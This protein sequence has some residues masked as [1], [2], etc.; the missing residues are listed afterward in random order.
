MRKKIF[1]I[2]D[3]HGH[4]T[5]TIEALKKAK[6][7]ENDP[8]HLL[9]VLGDIFDRGEQNLEIFDW[10][11]HLTQ[12]KKAIVTYGNHHKFLIDFLEG[13][14]NPFNYLRNG[15]NTT[16][17]D[18]WHRTDSFISWC[19]LDKK[20]EINDNAY[21]EWAEICRRDIN[22]EYPDLL[23]WLKAMPRYFESER[24]IGTHGAL[25]LDCE[26]WHEPK[27]TLYSLKGWDACDFDDGTF[28]DDINN[29][30]KTIVV[31]HFGT[32]A[33]RCGKVSS[34]EEVLKNCD[35]LPTDDNK[36]FLDATT[37]I[38]KKVNVYV[39]EDELLEEI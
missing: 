20:G 27:K 32:F 13:D 12:E 39:V 6:Y 18:F 26:D 17:D 9:V 36:I 33:L 29:T 24:Y 11:Y 14:N 8:N 5:E 2:S 16:I 21:A 7:N 30:G 3:L 38:T 23:P 34:K 19:R 1:F 4:F 25:D 22:K 37:V 31:G 15:L 35:I 28:I 10:L